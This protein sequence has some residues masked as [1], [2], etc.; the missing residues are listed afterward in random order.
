MPKKKPCP[1][2]KERNPKNG[3][4][5]VSCKPDQQRDSK[6]GRCRKIK[7]SAK[8]G[9]KNDL[10]ILVTKKTSRMEKTCD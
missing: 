8:P 6:T 3:R 1:P 5:R 4:C 10:R 2:G 9:S 7:A